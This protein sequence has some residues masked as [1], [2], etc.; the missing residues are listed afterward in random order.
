M[1]TADAIFSDILKLVE[2]SATSE[3]ILATVYL[4]L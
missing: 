3:L 1:K 4:K 2:K